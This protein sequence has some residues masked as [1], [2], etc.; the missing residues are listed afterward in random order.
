MNTGAL[1]VEVGTV[2]GFCPCPHQWFEVNKISKYVG[3]N[4]KIKGVV[5]ICANCEAQKE[6]WE[7]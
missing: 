1:R 6:L 4:K 5:V 7:K 2:S 3:V